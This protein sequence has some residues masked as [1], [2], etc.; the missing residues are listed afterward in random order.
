MLFSPA[1][2]GKLI[3]RMKMNQEAYMSFKKIT[4]FI[5]IVLVLLGGIFG[6]RH[7]KTTKTSAKTNL[8]F[9][10]IKKKD[11]LHKQQA[12]LYASHTTELLQEG[13]G[14]GQAIFIDEDG[15]A[16]RLRLDGLESGSTYY[17]KKKLYI[18]DANQIF[19]IGKNT[20]KQKMPSE[21][22]GIKSGYLPA[23]DQFYSL[24]NTGF[25]TKYDYKTSIRFGNSKEKRFHVSQVPSFISGVGEF[26]DR[27]VV[28][29]QNLINDH[30][31]L[32]EVFLREKEAKVI[33]LTELPLKHP[34]NLDIISP[35]MA[36]KNS[37]YFVMTDYQSEK[38]EDLSLII[39]NRQTKETEI[40]P[41][42][43]YR[44]EEQVDNGLPNNFNHSSYLYKNHFYYVNGL[45]EV[46]RYNCRDGKIQKYL[47]LEFESTA[48]HRL[49]QVRFQN[50]RIHHLYSDEEE[51]FFIETYNLSS[52]KREKLQ[53]IKMNGLIPQN[54]K[55]YFLTSIEIL[56]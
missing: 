42:I 50:G 54:D 47:N 2:Y 25:S 7:F 28:L 26:S 29:T 49:E 46:Y 41:F 20:K 24:Y 16:Q 51:D 36:D 44:S 15:N 43:S 38:R 40:K 56:N 53:K 55:D 23:T 33:K 48:N 37:Y 6:F 27:L 11:F 21:L 34:S 17:H 14:S 45:G 39:Y 5:G 30:F 18:E 32:Q 19:L 10:D 22:R 52:K 8:T 12:V 35:I 3:E 1:I 9:Q 4:V 13:K 31:L